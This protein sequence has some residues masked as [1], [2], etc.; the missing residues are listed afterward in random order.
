MSS[1]MPS[2]FPTGFNKKEEQAHRVINKETSR[3]VEGPKLQKK[4]KRS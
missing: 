3:I 1:S 2:F 4:K